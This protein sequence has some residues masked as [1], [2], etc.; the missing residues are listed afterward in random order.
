[1]TNSNINLEQDFGFYLCIFL[2]S[3]VVAGGV[4]EALKY[5]VIN[6]VTRIKPGYRSVIGYKI[7]AIA[8]A[9][10]FT[11][12]ENIGFQLIYRS[13]DYFEL[14]LNA[15]A[16]LFCSTPMHVACSLLIGLRVIQRDIF[17]QQF[18]IFGVLKWSIFF[19]GNFNFWLFI[20]SYGYVG[21][22]RIFFQ[23][24]SLISSPV[25][26]FYVIRNENKIVSKLQ[27]ESHILNSNEVINRL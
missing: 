18:T 24:I 14:F 11:V 12:M 15:I 3:F 6:R 27:T 10:G 4:E 13:E 21:N 7:I 8:A 25:G 1:M 23:L 26:L 17:K 5:F 20:A 9:L 2:F 22:W 16:R 19:H